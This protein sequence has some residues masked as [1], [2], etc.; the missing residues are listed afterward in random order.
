[1]VET[2]RSKV[3]GW[4]DVAVTYKTKDSAGLVILPWVQPLWHC[5]MG[6]A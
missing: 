6:P 2:L 5:P 1:M 4:L 3:L